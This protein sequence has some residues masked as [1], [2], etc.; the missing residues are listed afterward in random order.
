VLAL[1]SFDELVI[2]YAERDAVLGAHPLSAL[3]PDRNG[4]LRP[5]VAVDG[6]LVAAWDARAEPPRVEPLEALP[7]PLLERAEAAA[8]EAAAWLETR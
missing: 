2:G 5:F 7:T 8:A 1:P 6:R 3:V 4:R